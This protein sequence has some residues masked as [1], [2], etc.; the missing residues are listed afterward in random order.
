MTESCW[1]TFDFSFS[2]TFCDIYSKLAR[3]FCTDIRS[4]FKW[5]KSISSEPISVASSLCP[6]SASNFLLRSILLG[7]VT[8]LLLAYAWL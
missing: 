3:S 2:E 5:L 8:V 7:L 6:Y 1:K 4:L